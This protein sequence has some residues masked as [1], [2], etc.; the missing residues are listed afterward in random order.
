LRDGRIDGVALVGSKGRQDV[1]SGVHAAW[2]SAD[3]EAQAA[4]VAG[5]QTL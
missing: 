2:R 3:A 5:P 4:E 1:I